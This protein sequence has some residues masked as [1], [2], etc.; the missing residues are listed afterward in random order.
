[1]KENEKRDEWALLWA[2]HQYAEP[3][4]KEYVTRIFEDPDTENSHRVLAAWG[5]GKLGDKR[6]VDYLVKM[7]DDPSVITPTSSDPGH[8]LRAAQALSDI[9][10]WDFE[11]HKDSVAIVRRRLAESE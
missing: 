5:L 2:A 11:W 4:F 9:N 3:E 8:S 6:A 1:M 10:D 7:L